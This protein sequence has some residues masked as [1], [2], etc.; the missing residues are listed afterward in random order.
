MQFTTI[1]AILASAVL[2]SA[3]PLDARQTATR[4]VVG[5]FF[6]NKNGCNPPSTG[7]SFTFVQG[8]PGACQNLAVPVNG[9]ITDTNF[10]NNNLTRTIRFY[11]KPCNQLGSANFFDVTPLNGAPEPV[12]DCKSQLVVSYSTI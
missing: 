9:A 7:V 5:T 4:S 6:T 10:T 11:N 8:T 1:T 12:P 3:G 2:A